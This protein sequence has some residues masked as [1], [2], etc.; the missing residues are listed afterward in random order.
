MDTENEKKERKGKEEY[1]YS[2]ILA[3]TPL[4][5][6]SD[7][8]HTVF[9]PAHYTMSACFLEK[10]PFIAWCTTHFDILDCL[11]M[12]HQCDRQTDRRTDRIVIAIACV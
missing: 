3:G 8:D 6:R 9:L 11:G 7:M 10:R 5:K 4:T 2:A 1:L 12:D